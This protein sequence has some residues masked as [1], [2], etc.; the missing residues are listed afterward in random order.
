[1]TTATTFDDLPYDVVY[2]CVVPRLKSVQEAR[3]LELSGAL[4]KD[5]ALRGTS[6]ACAAWLRRAYGT[7][8]LRAALANGPRLHAE[9]GAM[10]TVH[11]AYPATT[12]CAPAILPVG[13][14]HAMLTHG[15][16]YSASP[17]RTGPR[18]DDGFPST[19]AGAVLA[20]AMYMGRTHDV[21]VPLLRAAPVAV[22]EK[23]GT[24]AFLRDACQLLFHVLGNFAETTQHTHAHACRRS[25][26]TLACHLHAIHD[27]YFARVLI[28]LADR[29]ARE[30]ARDA[31]TAIYNENENEKEHEPE[32]DRH[33]RLA[34]TFLRRDLMTVAT[35]RACLPPVIE[36]VLSAYGAP[37][38]EDLFWALQNTCNAAQQAASARDRAHVLRVLF[39][40]IWLAYGAPED[41]A[42]LLRGMAWLVAGT[43]DAELVLAYRDEVQS[44]VRPG[45]R[46]ARALGWLHASLVQRAHVPGVLACLSVRAT[47][48]TCVLLAWLGAAED[49][50]RAGIDGDHASL[51]S[52]FRRGGAQFAFDAVQV[53]RFLAA[54]L[55]PETESRRTAAF[56][57]CF[58]VARRRGDCA[59]LRESLLE[60]LVEGHASVAF[61]RANDASLVLRSALDVF[62]R[63]ARWKDAARR[64]NALYAIGRAPVAG[65]VAA[66]PCAALALCAEPHVGL[67]Y[68]QSALSVISDWCTDCIVQGK[69]EQEH[70]WLTS[71]ADMMAARARAAPH[72]TGVERA[73]RAFANDM[74]RAGLWNRWSR[75]AGP[76][77]R[78]SRPPKR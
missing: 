45:P 13:C 54:R 10:R 24:A 57:H 47:P 48:S 25:A 9:D 68:A 60:A 78:F 37:R 21:A 36:H 44:C 39:R 7:Q 77:L 17:S 76:C 46:A 19:E 70:V 8:A 74:R 12:T 55:P 5:A 43:E 22:T 33:A 69:D 11:D 1:M 14:A 16:S 2:E 27:A 40:P 51:D 28:M 34:E 64:F 49:A 30:R 38:A 42:W 73:L 65:L 63:S 62:I 67:P 61:C 75:A 53:M 3:R 31:N 4:G 52:T 59:S 20:T 72:L 6:P 58:A 15:V 66:N 26:E 50:V 56:V 18:Q 35:A 23:E 29:D 71:I 41:D 32:H